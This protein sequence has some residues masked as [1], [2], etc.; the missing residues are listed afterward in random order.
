M[1]F[2]I[3]NTIKC[4]TLL[5]FNTTERI[6]VESVRSQ[7][8]KLSSVYHPDVSNKRYKDGERFK[9]LNAA[10]E[11]LINNIDLVNQQIATNFSSTGYSSKSNQDPTYTKKQEEARRR[12]EER[13]R[14]AEAEAARWKKEAEEAK[15]RAYEAQRQAEEA[16]RASE[17]SRSTGGVG[18][19][20]IKWLSNNR[21]QSFQTMPPKKMTGTRFATVLGE[22]RFSTPFEAWCAITH[23]YEAPF[24]ENQFTK[25]GKAIEPKQLAFVRPRFRGTVVTPSDVW[26]SDYFSQTLGD[27]FSDTPIFGGMWDYYVKDGGRPVSV[28]EMKT[29]NVKNRKYWLEEIPE[30]YALQAA[31]YAYLLRVDQVYMIVTF[32]TDDDYSRLDSFSCRDTNTAVLPFKL[33]ERYPTFKR[34][35]IDVAADWWKRHVDTGLSPQYDTRARKDMF[36]VN[37]LKRQSR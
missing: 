35:Y 34:D 28:L 10:Q 4:L 15:R 36:I 32:L 5:E 23:T 7:Y 1:E 20:T 14:Y 31:L 30:N 21:I 33:S 22:N 16:K 11:Y 12:E 19:S 29:T 26:G 18:S 17:Q 6:S 25:A 8:R 2:S 27:F 24:E 37:E 13:R 3:I 9:E